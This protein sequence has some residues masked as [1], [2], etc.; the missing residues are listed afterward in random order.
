MT[1]RSLI[2]KAMLIALF[3]TS[4]LWGQSST[5][6]LL[7]RVT[8]TTGAVLPNAR[9]SVLNTET[10]VHYDSVSNSSGDYLVPYL[11]PG[12]YQLKVM[13]PVSRLIRELASPFGR[14]AQ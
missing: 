2:W 5:G 6:N 11:T 13:L 10:N 9:I 12:T 14:Q 7:G 1:I 4:S 8:D 3:S